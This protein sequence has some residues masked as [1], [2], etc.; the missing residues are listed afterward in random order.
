MLSSLFQ[1]PKNRSSLQ[2]RGD[3]YRHVCKITSQTLHIS[4]TTRPQTASPYHIPTSRILAP[5]LPHPN[6][7]P[8]RSFPRTARRGRAETDRRAHQRVTTSHKKLI[9]LN[10]QNLFGHSIIAS[11][12]LTKAAHQISIN[13]PISPPTPILPAPKAYHIHTVIFSPQLIQNPL[14]LPPLSEIP[15]VSQFLPVN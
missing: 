9:T 3:K 8:G 4:F 13:P 7:L 12:L 5:L 1:I 2:E 15:R 14:K 6:H 11:F 10:P